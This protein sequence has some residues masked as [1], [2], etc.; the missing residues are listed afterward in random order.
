[1][2]THLQVGDSLPSTTG[3]TS[4]N[5]TVLSLLEERRRLPRQRIDLIQPLWA[6]MV[7]VQRW[8]LMFHTLIVLSVEDEMTTFMKAREEG[9]EI[10][11]EELIDLVR[12]PA[13]AKKRVGQFAAVLGNTFDDAVANG[14][15][16]ERVELPQTR[17]TDSHATQL[18]RVGN[19]AA[20]AHDQGLQRSAFLPDH[21]QRCVDIS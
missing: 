14:A 4:H 12:D 9:E 13:K 15:A 16:V 2:L 5:L 11:E 17:A 10:G 20:I 19:F 3:D 8:L 21:R 6:R 7:D 18:C 1:M